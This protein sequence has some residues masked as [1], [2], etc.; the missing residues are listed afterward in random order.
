MYLVLFTG[1]SLAGGLAGTATFLIAAR[2]VQ[3]IGAAV[4]AP[5]TLTVLTSAYPEGPHR[6]RALAL[7]TAVGVAGGTAG[8]LLG[9][10]LTEFHSWRSIL[11]INVP[12]G[13]AAFV[14]ALRHLAGHDRV[15][16]RPRPDFAGAASVTLGLA[17]LAYGVTQAR[18]G[19][20]T[21]PGTVVSLG[22]AIGTLSGFAVVE[23]KTANP[24]FPPRQ[25][26]SRTIRVGN[27]LLLLA[28]ACL[29]P[30]WFFLTLAMQNVLQYSPLQTG[31]GF[32]PHTLVTIVVTTRLTPRPMGRVDDRILIAAGALIAA[33]GFLWQSRL[34]ADSGYLGGILAPAVLIATGAGLLNT[35]LTTTVTSGV[36]VA[37][38]GAASGLMNT[39]KQVGGALG[40]ATLVTVT[41]T[42]TVTASTA[43]AAYARA[44]LV[45]AAIM[46]VLAA[47]T[48]GLPTRR[49]DRP[50]S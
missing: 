19:G 20:W 33:A 30:M 27:V 22:I 8:N 46:A 43:A 12:I 36:D 44:F 37:D 49:N 21:A 39:A 34:T 9:G 1:A 18:T 10:A 31:L 45:L 25:L 48:A 42:V 47:L 28:G 5:A 2:A 7:W 23:A 6:T 16:S 40:L 38:A 26:R 32:L 50:P 29:N 35:P 24:L 11:L 13:A 15:T 41:V 14:L 4:L 17:A 3:G